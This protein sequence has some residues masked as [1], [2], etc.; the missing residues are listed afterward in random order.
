MDGLTN[1]LGRLR[2]DDPDVALVC[3]VFAEIERVYRDTLEAMGASSKHMPEVG[4]S[5]EVTISF[6]PTPSSCGE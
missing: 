3:D 4:N 6:R 2:E 5:A 1:E